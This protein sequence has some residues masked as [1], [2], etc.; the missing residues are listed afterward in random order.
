MRAFL[1]VLAF[2]TLKVRTDRCL[3]EYYQSNVKLDGAVY[4]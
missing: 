1:V 2:L 3:N 4:K